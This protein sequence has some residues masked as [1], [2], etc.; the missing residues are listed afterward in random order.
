MR[1]KLFCRA[2]RKLDT[3]ARRALPAHQVRQRIAQA[4]HVTRASLEGLRQRLDRAAL[5]R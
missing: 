5:L 1:Q 2:V 4:R 3:E